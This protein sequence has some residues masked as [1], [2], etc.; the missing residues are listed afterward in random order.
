MIDCVEA[1][2]LHNKLPI[3]PVAVNNELPQLFVT[4][5]P[6]ADGIA[7]TVSNAAFEFTDPSLFVHTARYCLLLSV[8]V[9]AK[10]N[11]AVVA[12]V[13]SVHVVPSGLTCHFTVGAGVPFA[14][15]VNVAVTPAHFVWA[16][17]CVVTVGKIPGGF[18]LL[19]IS[20]IAVLAC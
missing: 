20:R 11:V 8:V 1:L 4:V 18:G 17:G 3:V 13:I 7:F 19:L 15:D 6:G 9:T 10:E 2:L 14:A 5:T 16:A 12:P